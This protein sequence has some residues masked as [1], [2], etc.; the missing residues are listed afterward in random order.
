MRELLALLRRFVA[1]VNEAGTGDKSLVYWLASLGDDRVR[2]ALRLEPAAARR[3]EL[4]FPAAITVSG[5]V[6]MPPMGMGG[7]AAAAVPLPADT[8]TASKAEPLNY[9]YA[10]LVLLAVLCWLIIFAVPGVM[11]ASKL[12]ADTQAAADAY[13]AL[14][15][16]L[17]IPITNGIIAKGKGK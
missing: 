12:P 13:D 6:A 1:E 7:N 11:A 5:S 14:V 15:A 4:M 16:S 3:F 17:A 9:S 2:A 8:I 10:G